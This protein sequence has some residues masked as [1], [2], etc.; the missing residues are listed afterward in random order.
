DHTRSAFV[1]VTRAAE[2]PRKETERL[3]DELRVLGVSPGVLLV[4]ALTPP[5]CARCRG[6]LRAE[7]RECG[8]M[9]RS[10][11]A[12]TEGSRPMILAPLVAPPPRGVAALEAW[13]RRWRPGDARTGSSA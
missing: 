4:N 12:L 3:L 6:T 9:A 5:G 1:V 10:W 7:A 11:R 8:R 13:G 2:L